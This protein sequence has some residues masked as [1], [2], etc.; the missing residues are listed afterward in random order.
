MQE[1]EQPQVVKHKSKGRP[2]G[3]RKQP[4]G[5]WVMMSPD[6]PKAKSVKHHNLKSKHNRGR[7][8][9]K[10]NNDSYDS[11]FDFTEKPPVRRTS[12]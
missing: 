6:A 12:L 1:Q 10:H 3:L 2:K 11:L 9:K 7:S 5:T 4:D 8:G